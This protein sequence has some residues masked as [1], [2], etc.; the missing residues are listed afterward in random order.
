MLPP[1]PLRQLVNRIE[2][3]D[4]PVQQAHR[5]IDAMAVLPPN[6]YGNF[7]DRRA[8]R[9]QH[10][11]QQQRQPIRDVQQAQPRLGLL[12][13][14]R[15]LEEVRLEQQQRRMRQLQGLE[16]DRAQLAERRRNVEV[17]L[18]A[19]RAVMVERRRN[20]APAPRAAGR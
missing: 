4:G 2:Q 3:V 5:P 17:Q 10:A 15:H 6:P 12:Q 16:A 19:H 18:E 7:R 8:V 11:N 14:N 1:N 13:A 9:L 20:R